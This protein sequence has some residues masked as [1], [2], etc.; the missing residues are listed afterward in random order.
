MKKFLSI[1]LVFVLVLSL[2]PMVFAADSKISGDVDNDF[3]RTV[4]DITI[5]RR[6]L[7][8]GYGVTIIEENSDVNSD[9]LI[10]AKDITILRRYHAGGYGVQLPSPEQDLGPNET[11]QI[12][13]P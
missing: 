11:P 1:F 9:S 7:A 5:L 2:T 10:N 13:L 6:H 12:P 8:G 3:A 4:K